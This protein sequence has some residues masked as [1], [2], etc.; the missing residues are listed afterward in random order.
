M[1]HDLCKLFNDPINIKRDLQGSSVY[2][3]HLRAVHI[4]L[5]AISMAMLQRRK[6]AKPISQVITRKLI[7]YSFYCAILLKEYLHFYI[8]SF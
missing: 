6:I 8:L 5:K 7:Y 1:Q 3:C 2:R 4:N